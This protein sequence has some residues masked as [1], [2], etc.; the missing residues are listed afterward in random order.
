MSL[1]LQPMNRSADATPRAAARSVDQTAVP[2]IEELPPGAH[3]VSRRAGY[4]HHGIYVGAGRVMQYAGLCTSLH[5][6]PIEEVTL[7]R[8][9]AGHEV[10]VVAHPCAVHT[11][12]EAVARARS[13]IGEDRYRLLTNNCEHFCT[14]C[15]DGKARSEQ[16][17]VCLAHPLTAACVVRA[18][19]RAYRAHARRAAFA[20]QAA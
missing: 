12:P 16:V 2:A 1:D 11:G 8:F 9:A 15:V 10:A 6:G 13:R 7:E 18:L 4:S 19:L 3:L 20:L 5:R 14:W 17:R